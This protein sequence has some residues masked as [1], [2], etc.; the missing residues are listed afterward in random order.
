MRFEELDGFLFCVCPI[1]MLVPGVVN[2]KL[3]S[4]MVLAD[5]RC[6]WDG[7]PLLMFHHT[8]R[9]HHSFV[10]N[11]SVLSEYGLGFIRDTRTNGYG[12][13]ICDGWFGYHECARVW[14]GLWDRLQRGDKIEVSTSMYTVQSRGPDIIVNSMTPDHLAI[15]PFGLVGACSVA[16]GGG[17]NNVRV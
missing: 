16:M 5:S 6:Q 12:D 15:L 10:T 13:L 9:Q 17:V 2:S 4:R 3:Y 1:T 8:V 11:T 7:V 14:P